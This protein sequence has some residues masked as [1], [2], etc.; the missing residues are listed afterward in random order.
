[1]KITER[2][3]NKIASLATSGLGCPLLQLNNLCRTVRAS[4]EAG[5]TDEQAIEKGRSFITGLEAK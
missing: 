1:M 2:K 5:D 4:L 3:V